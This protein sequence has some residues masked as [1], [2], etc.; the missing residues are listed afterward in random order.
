LTVAKL[1]L[2]RKPPAKETILNAAAVLFARL[3][4]DGTSFSDITD[5][6][7]A[8]RPLILY[9]YGTKEELWRLAVEHIS[10]RFDEEMKARLR[11]DASASDEEKMRASM[12]AFIDTLVAVPEFGQIL[13]RE[14]TTPGPRLDWIAQN[15]APPVTLTIRFKSAALEHKMKRTVL[16]DVITATFL[17]TV[18]LGPL[19]EAS[20]AAALRKKAGVYPLTKAKRDE[21][22]ALMMKLALD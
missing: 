11:I 15:F 10:R 1:D 13:L 19:L 12:T 5:L 8:K 4:F 7:G 22:I 16:R 18:M 21:V 2:Q 14:G 17:A 9:H 20:L 3:G 6:C